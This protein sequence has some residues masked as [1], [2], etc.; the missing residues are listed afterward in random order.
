MV[1]CRYRYRRHHRQSAPPPLAG[2][3]ASLPEADLKL[4]AS[5]PPELHLEKSRRPMEIMRSCLD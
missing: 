2:T 1:G 4:A 5:F 3:L